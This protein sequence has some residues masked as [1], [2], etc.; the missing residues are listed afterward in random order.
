MFPTD[1]CARWSARDSARERDKRTD[2]VI[3]R[4]E[5]KEEGEKKSAPSGSLSRSCVRSSCSRV[6]AH[7]A[8]RRGASSIPTRIIARAN[9]AYLFISADQL[10]KLAITRLCETDDRPLARSPARS[11]PII[12]KRTRDFSSQ[13]TGTNL[14]DRS[15]KYLEIMRNGKLCRG[16]VG[17]ERG[18]A[19]RDRKDPRSR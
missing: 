16:G 6:P 14:A 12:R 11:D 9:V 5:A 17:G 19:P 13:T 8:K 4:H 15:F 3:R 10:R 7:E 2:R 18:N 1:V